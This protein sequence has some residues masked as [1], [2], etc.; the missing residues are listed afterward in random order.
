MNS[1][2]TYLYVYDLMMK[3]SSKINICLLLLF[4][5]RNN[6]FKIKILQKEQTKLS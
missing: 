3:Y 5:Y 1:R 6:L 4:L 2:I